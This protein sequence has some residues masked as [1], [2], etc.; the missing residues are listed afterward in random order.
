MKLPK[1]LAVIIMALALC[2]ASMMPAMAAGTKCPSCGSTNTSALNDKVES[3]TDR[4]LCIH[5]HDGMH[6]TVTYRYRY[7]RIYCYNCKTEKI[8]PMRPREEMSRI[9]DVI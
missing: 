6:D 1:K 8:L 9:C 7:P 2:M 5:G 4:E 3:H